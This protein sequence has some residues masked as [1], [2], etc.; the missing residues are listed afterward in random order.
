MSLCIPIGS[1]D[2]VCILQLM[3]PQRRCRLLVLDCSPTE[4]FADSGV[5]TDSKKYVFYVT[6]CST[7][8][9]EWV[10]CMCIKMEKCFMRY[11]S[12]LHPVQSDISLLS[13]FF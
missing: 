9:W 13:C 8:R 6:Q 11:L 12:L 10:G 4:H 7:H 2:H 5:L 3:Q 1:I